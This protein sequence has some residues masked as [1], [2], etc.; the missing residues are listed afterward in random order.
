LKYGRFYMLMKFLIALSLLLLLPA[1]G[2]AA[3]ITGIPKIREGDQ[4]V[5]GNAVGGSAL[6][7]HQGRALDLRRRRARRTDQACRAQDLDLSHP[8]D[9]PPRPPGGAVRSRR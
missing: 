1:V 8:P 9:R 2:Q 3:D 4:I 6:P 7:Q 5:I